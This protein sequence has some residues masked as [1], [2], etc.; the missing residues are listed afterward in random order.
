M[1]TGDAAD[2]QGR[3]VSTIPPWFPD[4]AP[5]EG[6]MLAA[7]GDALSFTYGAYTYAKAQTRIGTAFGAWLDLIAWDFFGARFLRRQGEAD[8]QFQPRIL[9]EILRPRQT[10]GAIAEALTDLTGV[11]PDIDEPWN[12]GDC[13]AYGIAT[14]YGVGGCYGSL[15]LQYQIFVTAYLPAGP[16]I[17]FVGGYGG[18]LIGYGV[19]GE[20]ADLSLMSGPVTDAQIYETV[21]E[22]V[23]A[24]VTAWV[25]IEA[26]RHPPM[27]SS[28][29]FDSVSLTADAN[30]ITMDND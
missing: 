21:A 12:P 30:T 4:N 9:D 17:P 29:S 1:T 2:M 24:G 13:G 3:L 27:L 8:A 19:A 7:I 23:A 11:V 25:A 20:Y 16:G 18:G 28:D 10:R 14:G 22:T 6:G 15:S 26:N 5:V